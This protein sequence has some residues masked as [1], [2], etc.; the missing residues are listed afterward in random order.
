MLVMQR[1]LPANIASILAS[2]RREVLV[3][4]VAGGGKKT[5]LAPRWPPLAADYRF[6][7][8]LTRAN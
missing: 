1:E 8:V 3:V 2:R 5:Q 6:F 7:F 4:A